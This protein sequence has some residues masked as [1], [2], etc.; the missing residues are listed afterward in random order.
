M[1]EI[2]LQLETSMRNL[3]AQV[4]LPVFSI[5]STSVNS[6]PTMCYGYSSENSLPGIQGGVS[7][8]NGKEWL[9][10][11]TN[12]VF[13]AA[14]IAESLS[15]VQLFQNPIDCS[16]P[17]SSVYGT[18]QT[19]ILEWAAISF[20]RVSS[21]P[22]NRTRVS[23]IGRQV[24]DHRMVACYMGIFRL[25]PRVEFTVIRKLLHLPAAIQ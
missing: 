5:T 21:Q 18:S 9:E 19:R 22:R 25:W 3:D 2:N 15:R 14:A 20:S 11:G 8:E 7:P 13:F 24:L 10:R 16:P 6:V 4:S 12:G 23:R 1:T 17:G